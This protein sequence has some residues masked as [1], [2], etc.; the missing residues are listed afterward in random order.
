MSKRKELS[1]V[2]VPLDKGPP[3]FKILIFFALYRDSP[4]DNSTKNEIVTANREKDNILIINMLPL[5]E[6][7]MFNEKNPVISTNLLK[8]LIIRTFL[9]KSR[10]FLGR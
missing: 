6:K 8:V 5:R 3:G 10:H 7:V 9:F 4:R 1:H 2:Q